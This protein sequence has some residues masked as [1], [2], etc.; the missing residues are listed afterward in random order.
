MIDIHNSHLYQFESIMLLIWEES[1]M[2]KT[3]AEEMA[4]K[5]RDLMNKLKLLQR[6]ITIWEGRG[7]DKNVNNDKTQW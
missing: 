1:G 5:V 3:E 4:T 7:L 2:M 6:S